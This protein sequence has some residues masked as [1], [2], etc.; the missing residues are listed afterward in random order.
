MTHIF[1]LFCSLFRKKSP[2][3]SHHNHPNMF[4]IGKRNEDVKCIVPCNA[5]NHITITILLKI[6]TI[7]VFF[8]PC[9]AFVQQKIISP[10]SE[11][12]ILLMFRN[13][14]ISCNRQLFRLL[15]LTPPQTQHLLHIYTLIFT[16]NF[17]KKSRK[18]HILQVRAVLPVSEF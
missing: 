6:A 8:L 7:R 9:A 11:R 14:V 12:K 13:H 4:F 3:K 1:F 16:W 5:A 18:L 15:I 10:C 2:Q 17:I